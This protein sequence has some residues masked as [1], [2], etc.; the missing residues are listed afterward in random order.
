MALDYNQIQLCLFNIRRMM[1]R[2]NQEQ[3]KA[4]RQ[5]KKK[6]PAEI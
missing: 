3:A 4:R 5:W 2:F 6:K 1:L